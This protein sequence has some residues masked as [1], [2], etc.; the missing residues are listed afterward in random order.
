[1]TNKFRVTFHLT[2]KKQRAARTFRV[3]ALFALVAALCSCAGVR[4]D[5]N[6]NADGSGKMVLEYRVSQTAEALGKLDGNERWQTVPVGRADFERTLAR[7]PS[8]RLASFTSS[9]TETD[10][11]N[12]AEIEF[13]NIK[14]LLPFLDPRGD[15]KFARLDTANGKNRLRVIL[16][17]GARD[18]DADLLDLI[19]ELSAGYECH[20]SLSVPR[21]A[22]L[23]LTDG[24]G[25]SLAA[26]PEKAA[27]VSRGKKV[28]LTAGTGEILSLPRGLGLEFVW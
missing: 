15:G 10:T 3:T 16:A 1:M 24:Q 8:L 20:F 14:D 4:A 25:E 11:V 28:S 9:N 19:R 26:V 6:I 12:R 18:I 27:V 5:I 17:Q 23:A 2:E 7:L 22:D 21:A 13:A